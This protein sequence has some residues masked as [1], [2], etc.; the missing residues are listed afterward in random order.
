MTEVRQTSTGHAVS[1]APW[2]DLHFQS[3]RP[4]YEASLRLVG[5][6]PG[7]TVLDAGCGGGN[8]LPLMGELV[9]A[10]GRVVAV[11]LAPKNIARV[12]SLIRQGSCPNSVQTQV[13]SVLALPFDDA[14]FDCVGVP[15]LSNILIKPNSRKR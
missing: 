14:T 7:W 6:Q 8:F 9:G 13:G 1:D 12:D 15:I 11:D 3:A 2:L 5:M 10:R 4:E